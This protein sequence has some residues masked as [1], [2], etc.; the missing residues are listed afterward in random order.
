MTGFDWPS[1]LIGAAG[2]AIFTCLLVSL[3]FDLANWR[4]K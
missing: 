2:G 4:R 3:A 1:A